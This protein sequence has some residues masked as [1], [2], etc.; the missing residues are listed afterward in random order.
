MK[1]EQMNLPDTGEVTRFYESAPFEVDGIRY[2]PPQ[3]DTRFTLEFY[4]HQPM[5]V[6][7]SDGGDGGGNDSEYYYHHLRERSRLASV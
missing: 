1:K 4:R 3:R 2:Y 7:K 5:F 6:L